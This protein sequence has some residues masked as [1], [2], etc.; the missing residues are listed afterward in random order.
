MKAAV[1]E[2][3]KEPL[4]IKEVSLREE[5]QEDEVLVE[6]KAAA[7]NHRDLW[8]QEGAYAKIKL[9]CILGSDGAGIIKRVG[10][11]NKEKRIGEEVIINPNIDWGE[12]ERHQSLRYRLLGMPDDGTFAEYIIVKEDR[13]YKKPVHLNFEEAAALPLGGLTAYRALF[14]RGELKPGEKVFINGIGGGVAW[15]A[16]LFAL[17][18]GA[19]VYISSSSEEKIKEALRAGVKGGINYKNKEEFKSLL[20][21]TGGMDL[22]IDSAGGEGFGNLITLAKFG[23]RIVFYG[24][25]AG[26]W[27]QVQAAPAFWKQIDIKGSTMGS[28]KEFEQMLRFVT[29][30]KIVPRISRIFALKEAN[31]AFKYM[32]NQQQLGKIVLKI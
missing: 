8:I 18:V 30:R 29:E 24:I 32:K 14:T 16:M 10:S 26:F 3:I 2:N 11:K 21:K 12:N 13:V 4:R 15:F 1:L 17:N 20:R 7:L 28:D 5:L 31:E 27:N 6:L 22:I 23:G 9:P 19:E 25:T